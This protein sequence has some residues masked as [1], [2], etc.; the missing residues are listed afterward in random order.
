MLSHIAIPAKHLETLFWPAQLL[1][2]AVKAPS[3][4]IFIPRQFGS[5]LGP[6]TVNM[7]DGEEAPIGF[8]ATDAPAAIG[9]GH[10]LVQPI[11]H[12][13]LRFRQR[14]RTWAATLFAWCGRTTSARATLTLFDAS[15]SIAVG[16]RRLPGLA[17]GA[18]FV[19]AIALSSATHAA[20]RVVQLGSPSAFPFS[21]V[22]SHVHHT[23]NI[24]YSGR[25]IKEAVA[26]EVAASA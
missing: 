20:A 23:V 17:R 1:Q 21:F 3:T 18:D 4:N 22:Y 11:R 24:P 19:L 5:V 7:I 8:A 25:H 16:A 9:D 2:C 12:L 13:S 10:F 26:Q 6:M 14:V 15:C